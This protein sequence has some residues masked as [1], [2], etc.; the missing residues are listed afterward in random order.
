MFLHDERGYAPPAATTTLKRALADL[1]A[2]QGRAAADLTLALRDDE[3]VR[4]LNRQFRG[5]DRVTDVLS[6]PAGP[7]A[8][9]GY[10]GDIV[11]ACPYA[12]A[13]ARA[14][15]RPLQDWL[16][17]LAVH[18]ALHLL[19]YSHDE[20]TERAE[21]WRAQATALAALGLAGGGEP[22]DDRARG[23]RGASVMTGTA[24]GNEPT[25]RGDSR[26][27]ERQRRRRERQR[28]QRERAARGRRRAFPQ[29]RP[30]G[31]FHW[32]RPREM[33]SLLQQG[34]PL[35]V[36]LLVVAAITAGFMYFNSL[37]GG[38]AAAQPNA[39][40][41]GPE[42]MGSVN[43][44]EKSLT[45][46][47]QRVDRQRIGALYIWVSALA[48]DN[49]WLSEE[50]L[51]RLR[52]FLQEL[53]RRNDELTLYGWLSVPLTPALGGGSL[54][55]EARAQTLL[56]F[57]RELVEGERYGFDGVLLNLQPLPDDDESVLRL[58]R[59]LSGQLQA[60]GGRLA[61]AA[62]PDYHPEAADV[63]AAAAI[64]PGTEWSASF[65]QE[66]ALLADELV[67]QGPQFL[68]GSGRRLQRLAGLSGARLRGNP[69][70]SE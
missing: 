31:A 61:L 58:L 28:G 68:P 50:Q 36:A 20:E 32:P 23:R 6:F 14:S 67:L 24:T 63:P 30:R 25:L 51:P 22:G 52:D 2:A 53:R 38:D 15:E 1:L 44:V 16:L 7:A 43:A 40:W 66:V 69:A 18:G 12:Q 64:R 47:L 13:L 8:D 49:R 34:F 65:K 17:L 9:G 26:L 42:W 41:L 35:L 62:A 10:L 19:G 60:V 33:L 27:R 29:L 48:G 37:A 59:R 46:L 3:A 55:D 39:L 4:A 54:Q 5:D 11:I 56:D 57:S 70:S 45:A 21:M